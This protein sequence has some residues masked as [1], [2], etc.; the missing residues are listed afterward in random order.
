MTKR[1]LVP[2]NKANS[3][4]ICSSTSSLQ[5]K[6]A[7][8]TPKKTLVAAVYLRCF[9]SKKYWG[10]HLSCGSQGSC[11]SS[12]FFLRDSS[13]HKEAEKC[14]KKHP[15]FLFC[16][17]S[18]RRE[19]SYLVI[20]RARVE[21]IKAQGFRIGSFQRNSSGRIRSQCLAQSLDIRRWKPCHSRIWS[22]NQ[23]G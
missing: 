9:E 20:R 10:M 6:T 3:S 21:F 2:W 12:H 4:I 14:V 13:F 8:L 16:L 23:Q 1:L 17:Q 15:S 19:M 11:V 5:H 22:R 18:A 7:T